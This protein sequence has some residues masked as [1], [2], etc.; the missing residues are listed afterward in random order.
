MLKYLGTFETG[1]PTNKNTITS[2]HYFF[3]SSTGV[4]YMQCAYAHNLNLRNR[5]VP[6]VKPDGTYLTRRDW[7]VAQDEGREERERERYCDKTHPQCLSHYLINHQEI[8]EI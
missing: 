2:T 6:L 7:L 8:L 5:L 1:A 3:E 4:V